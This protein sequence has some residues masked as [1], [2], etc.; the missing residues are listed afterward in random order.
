MGFEISGTTAIERLRAASGREREELLAEFLDSLQTYLRLVA[1]RNLPDELRAKVAPSDII[2]STY[3]EARQCLK[4]FNGKS[5]RD[6]LAWFSRILVN[7]VKDTARQYQ[8]RQKRQVSREVPLGCFDE[9]NLAPATTESPGDIASASE[10]VSQLKEAI[11]MLPEEYRQ[12]IVLRSLERRSLAEV[13]QIMKRTE[14]AARKLFG[15]ALLQ[16]QKHMSRSD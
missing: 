10:E 1:D 14:D 15:R 13:G 2:Q 7:N 8:V 3:I 9:G 12:V 6:L 5:D 16:L 11:A 4:R